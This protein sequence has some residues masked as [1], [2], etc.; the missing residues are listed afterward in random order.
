MFITRAD[1]SPYK[2][3]LEE[4]DLLIVA[5]TGITGLMPTITALEAGKMQGL[6]VSELEEKR[7]Q[8]RPTMSNNAKLFNTARKLAKENFSLEREMEK[9]SG[10]VKE[11]AFSSSS[12][13]PD[14]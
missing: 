1:I 2:A 14:V 9:L 10:I 6:N 3:K 8:L 5:S 12:A 4:I 11:L 13:R 7:A